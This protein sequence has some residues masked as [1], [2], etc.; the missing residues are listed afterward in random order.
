MKNLKVM[1]VGG[2]FDNN[3]EYDP[4]R[5]SSVVT[6]LIQYMDEFSGFD[7]DWINGGELQLIREDISYGS[8]DVLI[9]MPNISN[10]ESKIINDIKLKHPKL[11]LI[12]SKRVV[13]KEYKESDIVGR[14]LK[15]KSNLGIMITKPEKF[16]HFKLL[17]PLGNCYV[18][19]YSIAGLA[20]AIIGRVNELKSMNRIPSIKVGDKRE[21][22]IDPE[23][24]EFVKYSADEFTKY[25]NAVNP[26]RLLGNASTRCMF[27]FPAERQ[28]ERLFV[29][30]RNIDKQLIEADGFVEVVPEVGNTVGY[31]G[32]KKPSVDTP[33]QV[34]LFDYYKNINYMVHGHVYI[35]GAKKTASKVPC[36]F[37]EEF[38]E[39]VELYPSQDEEVIVVNLRG[40]GCLIMTNTVDQLWEYGKNYVSREFPEY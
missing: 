28:K 12:S 15:T 3:S 33:I 24:I 40:H 10:D 18:D 34:K 26:N 30:Q 7:C 14:L 39:I 8:Y 20:D 1:I 11:M 27:G 5:E 2:T 21:F 9:W 25:V 32:D 29:S 13:E 16:Y 37:L 35:D 17:D 23:F 6:K 4:S 19:T 36:G 22:T 38:D 31:Y